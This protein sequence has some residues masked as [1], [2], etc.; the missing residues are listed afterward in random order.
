[1]A[2][3]WNNIY[4]IRFRSGLKYYV[5]NS[6]VNH[7]PSWYIRK[8]LYKSLGV[9]LGKG[10]RIGLYTVIDYPK[11]I[12]I[13]SRSIINEHC[14]LDGRGGI[15]IEDDV[16]ISI[17]T[18]I[19]S[20]SH[21]VDSS[22]FKYFEEEV[23]IEDNVWIGAGAIILNGSTLKKGTIIG[24]GCIYK[25]NSEEFGIYMGNPAKLVKYRKMDSMYHLNYRPWIR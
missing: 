17:Y 18:K 8:V 11:G 14:F 1:M 4:F 3:M 15:H 9:K 2:R 19:I 25:G 6:V 21:E 24:A 22:E 12:S 10:S 16:S 13:G 23:L 20:A 5:L 7:I